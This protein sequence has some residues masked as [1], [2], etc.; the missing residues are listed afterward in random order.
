MWQLA[1]SDPHGLV[2]W[3]LPDPYPGLR[4]EVQALSG[5]HIEG[6]VPRIEVPH[7][8]HPVPL[9][10]VVARELRTQGCLIRLRPEGLREGDEEFPVRAPHVIPVRGLGAE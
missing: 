10:R 2:S 4:F 7:R 8:V 9:G 1:D 5:N 6:L 3:P